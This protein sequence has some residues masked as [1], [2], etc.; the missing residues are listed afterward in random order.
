MALCKLYPLFWVK[1]IVIPKTFLPDITRT[2]RFDECFLV[3][4]RIPARPG[5]R[6]NIDEKDGLFLHQLRNPFRPLPV[7]ISHR[8]EGTRGDCRSGW[9][10]HIPTSSILS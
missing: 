1:T 3:P 5:A 7:G 8:V 2:I 10:A 9:C 4:L 6:T